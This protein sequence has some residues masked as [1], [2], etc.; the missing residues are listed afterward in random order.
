MT[1]EELLQEAERAIPLIITKEGHYSEYEA[2][3]AYK[4]GIDYIILSIAKWIIL[5]K[6]ENG[7]K[8]I[9]YWANLPCGFCFEYKACNKC[10]ISYKNIRLGCMHNF[11]WGSLAKQLEYLLNESIKIENNV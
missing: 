3:K 11:K 7:G 1:R 9:A 6:Q 2:R 4:N 10:P 8:D 5:K